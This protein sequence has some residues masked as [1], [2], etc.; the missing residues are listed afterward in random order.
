[1]AVSKHFVLWYYQF[2]GMHL[3]SGLHTVSK[4]SIYWNYFSTVVVIGLTT[5]PLH[6]N[7]CHVLQAVVKT[8]V[9]W[10]SLSICHFVSFLVM[11]HDIIILYSSAFSANYC[12]VYQITLTTLISPVLQYQSSINSYHYPFFVGA[13]FLWNINW[14]LKLPSSLPKH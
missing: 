9:Y 5:D 11:A 10:W 8:Y 3:Q 2:L 12:T 13:P 4:T 7:R 1:M 6:I 14:I